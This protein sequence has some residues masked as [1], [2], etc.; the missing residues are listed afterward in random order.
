MFAGVVGAP[1]VLGVLAVIGVGEGVSSVRARRPA[2]GPAGL[3]VPGIA[4]ATTPLMTITV[5]SAATEAAV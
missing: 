2:V 4:N 3:C 1:G 5:T